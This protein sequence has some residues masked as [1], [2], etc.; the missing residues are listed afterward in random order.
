MSTDFDLDLLSEL[1]GEFDTDIAPSGIEARPPGTAAPL[2]L[3]QQRLWFLHELAEG[4]GAYTIGSSFRLQGDLDVDA[5]LASVADLIRR[6][7]SLRTAITS[8]DGVAE[9]YACPP[10]AA[11][12]IVYADWSASVPAHEPQRQAFLIDAARAMF[13]EPF[14]LQLGKPFRF[15][16]LRLDA[17]EHV[18]QVSLHHLFGD[19]TSITLL[20]RDLVALYRARR[21]GQPDGLPPL[22]VHYLDFAAWQRRRPTDWD[23]ALAFWRAQLADLATLD[24]P[25]DRSRP[26]TSRGKGALLEITIPARTTATLD[27]LARNEGTTLFPVVVAGFMSLLARY[28]RQTDIAVGTS[29]SGR[30]RIET[31]NMIGFFANMVVLRGNLDGAPSLRDLV[32]QQTRVIREA[33]NHAALPYERLVEALG[34]SREAG[35]NPL[36]QVA[37]SLLDQAPDARFD[38]GEGLKV[39]P[40]TTQEASR[41]DLEIFL[42]REGTQLSGAVSYDADLFERASV[43]RMMSQWVALLD[44]A[45]QQPD[46]PLAS[47]PL[48]AAASPP[49][50]LT[51][52]APPAAPFVSVDA[53]VRA[54]A[55][56][57]PDACALR[58]GARSLTYGELD[59]QAD[60]LA[61]RLLARDIGAGKHIGL[62]FEPGFAMIVSMLA[63]VRVGATYV[64]IDPDYPAERIQIIMEDAMLA[65]VLGDAASLARLPQGAAIPASTLE[66]L[67]TEALDTSVST[68]L[69]PGDPDSI[70][71]VIFTSG[72]TGRPKG[73][74]VSAANLARLF[75]TTDTLFDFTTADIWTLTH[76]YAF[77]FSVW[78]IWGAL[79]HGSTLLIVPVA[80]R[81]AADSLYALLCDERVTVLNQT[82]SSF[83]QLMAEEERTGREAELALRYVIFGGEA[84]ELSSLH[85]WIDRH[86]DAS[87]QLV[88]MYGITE[89]TV[90][91]TYRRIGIADVR[92]GSGSLIGEPLPDMSIRL[93]DDALRPVPAGMIGEIVVGGAGVSKG[94]LNRPELTSARFIDDGAGGML[95]RSGDL[96]RRDAHGRLEY[97][98]RADQQIKL[99][100]F[101]IELGEIEAVLRTHPSVADAT[102]MVIGNHES[103]R[104]AAYA[105]LNDSSQ[106]RTSWRDSFDMIYSG[107]AG[108][109]PND[110]L[111]DL[112]GWTDSYDG[113]PIPANEMRAW[114]DEILSRIGESQGQRVLEIGTGTGMLLLPL[115]AA[116]QRYDGLDFSAE[117]IERLSRVVER[118]G[119]TSVRL[120]A[121]GADDLA[122]LPHDYDTIIVNSVL[123]YFPDAAYALRVI[124]RALDHLAPGGRLILGDL[125]HL[126][127][128]RHFQASRLLY[129]IDRADRDRE[130]DSRREAL[131]EA[132][133]DLV[134]EEKELLVAPALFEAL[135]QARGDIASADI[136]LKTFAGDNELSRYRY[137]VIL[138]K[139]REDDG[140]PG[141]PQAT[142]PPRIAL[143]PDVTR[144]VTSLEAATQQRDAVYVLGELDNA[145]LAGTQAF[146]DW[147]DET[148]AHG[149]EPYCAAEETAANAHGGNPSELAD[150]ARGAGLAL[151][152]RWREG[153]GRGGFEVELGATGAL[154][155]DAASANVHAGNTIETGNLERFFNTPAR[156]HL[157][158]HALRQ[159]LSTRLPPY[160]VPAFVMVLD[161]LPLTPNGKLD[162]AA[163]PSLESAS[164]QSASTHADAAPTTATERAIAAVFAEVLGLAEV[165]RNDHFF[166]LGGHSLL[167]TQVMT[168]LRDEHGL[169][170]KLRVLFDHPVVADLASV[171][172]G[173]T[174]GAIAQPVSHAAPASI[175]SST[176]TTSTI[177]KLDERAQKHAAPAS[178]P[179]SF[180]QQRFWF[181]DRLAGDDSALYHMASVLRLQGAL[182]FTAV[183]R[184]I[185]ALGTRHESL[186]TAFTLVDDVP[187]QQVL[188]DLDV[189]LQTLAFAPGEHGEDGARAVARRFIWERFD[190]SIG[191]PIRV[192]L[193]QLAK[194]DALLI[195]CMHHIVSD[196]WSLGIFAREF[197]ALYADATP[198]APLPLRYFDHAIAQRA[199]YSDGAAEGALK[200]WLTRLEGAPETL[201]LAGERV[202]ER[203]GQHDGARLTFTLNPTET[204]RLQSLAHHSGVTLF[205]VLLTAY[206]AVL[207]RHAG[208]T[209]VV[210]GSPIAQRPNR[211]SEGIIGC[212]LNTLP[213][214]CTFD[215]QAT[216]QDALLRTRDVVLDA[217]EWQDV[218]FE[219]LVSALRQTRDL[220][221]T[222]VFQSFLSLQN[223]PAG[224]LTLPGLDVSSFDDG[225]ELSVQFKLT[226]LAQE[227]QENGT[228]HFDWLY[229]RQRFDK[230]VIEQLVV[231]FRALL[232]AMA[233]APDAL[234][235]DLAAHERAGTPTQ[236]A[237]HAVHALTS[238]VTAT[239]D[240]ALRYWRDTLADAPTTLRVPGLRPFV[241]A[242]GRLDIAIDAALQ[243]NLR[244]LGEQRGMP[245]PDLLFAAWSALLAR[246]SAQE[247]VVLLR[248]VTD[249]ADTHVE[250]RLV[251]ASAVRIDITEGL[252]ISALLE[253]VD[254]RLA[255]ARTHGPTPEIAFARD[256]TPVQAGFTLRTG[257]DASSLRRTRSSADLILELDVGDM[258]TETA[259]ASATGLTVA[260]R[261]AAERIDAA[262]LASYPTYLYRILS[263][264]AEDDSQP[265]DAISLLNEEEQR[266]QWERLRP[267]TYAD[268]PELCL[269]ESFAARASRTPDA[270]AV[271]DGEAS[272][273][274]AELDAR[275]NRLAHRLMRAGVQPDDRVVLFA[276]PGLDM[277]V[278]LLGILKA[279]A[280]YVPL[281]P[282]YPV[283]RVAYVLED[284]QPVAIVLDSALLPLLPP[285]S[286]PN[287]RRHLLDDPSLADESSLAPVVPALRTHHLAYVIY[288]SG[289]TGQPK[290]V[291]VEHRNVA[292]LFTTTETAYDFTERD[293]WALFHSFAF[294]FSVWEIWGAWLYGGRLVIVPQAVRRD[295]LA[296]YALL[297]DSGITVLN[298]TPSAFRQLVAVQGQSDARH[299][300]R[301]VIFG[302]E[303]LEPDFLA[304]WYANAM[305]VDTRLTNMYGITET[306]VHVTLHPLSNVDADPHAGDPNRPAGAIGMP[307]A[308]LQV[309]ILD[310]QRRPVPDGVV[311]EM[312][313]S[314]P[315][316]ARGYLNRPALTEARFISHP[317]GTHATD[318][319]YRSG[320]LARRLANGSLEYRGRNDQQVK[321]RGFRIELGEI[322]ARLRLF[323]G[324]G[325]ACVVV[326]DHGDGDKRLVAYVVPAT[327]VAAAPLP[328]HAPAAFARELQA[329]LNASLPEHMVPKV[330]VLVAALPLTA[331]GKL[332]RA[333]L[334]SP[335]T[336]PAAAHATPDDDA[337]VT[338][339]QQVMLSLWSAVLG[340]PVSER[341]RSFFDVGGD[342]LLAVKLVS[343]I[344][345]HFHQ[346]M[347]LATAFTHQTVEALSRYVDTCAANEVD[348][349]TAPVGSLGSEV[350][351]T[352]SPGPASK[353]ERTVPT[354]VLLHDISGLFVSQLPLARA[355]GSHYPV[356]G[357]Q[358]IGLDGVTAPLRSVEAMAEAYAD[359]IL[360]AGHGVAPLVLIGYSWG[361]PVSAYLARALA[362]RGHG[363]ALLVVLDAPPG[364]NQ[365]HF[366]DIPADDA[367]L[368]AYLSEALA[369]STGY[370]VTIPASGFAALE[371]A[372]RIEKF[373]ERCRQ[374]KLVPGD[375]PTSLVAGM[376]AVYRANLQVDA[377]IAAAPVPCPI[378]VWRSTAANRPQDVP[379]HL[380]WSVL[381]DGRIDVS[382]VDSDH[383]GMLRPPHVHEL[384]TAIQDR[385]A[386]LENRLELHRTV[387]V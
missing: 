280:A 314:G 197:A 119:L 173:S 224:R 6:H 344:E 348:T 283:D 303:A 100:G 2:S 323:D 109:G 273:S 281:D 56:Q 190:L 202:P 161:R 53:R 312:Y 304:A 93:V 133:R 289:S 43:E 367:G 178:A 52:T 218:P 381:S 61:Q 157:L 180:A 18:V 374:Q 292:R 174:N 287:L 149:T 302:G 183:R 11:A 209:E 284:S 186:R 78:E 329:W 213:L 230:T 55:A 67:N 57:R 130:S 324:A 162:R 1:S 227:L 177:E 382:I 124:Q 184:A 214:R 331:N 49:T 25:L 3:P 220:D 375:T 387:D 252:S 254:R 163:L 286:A 251:T 153:D 336:V 385:I 237:P 68:P 51:T 219:A 80:V 221:R 112:A 131:R 65:M 217:F 75:T 334:P 98:G 313:V 341:T 32:R 143:T 262:A 278:G 335:A 106:T 5:F 44:E 102:V 311:G 14:D 235:V 21:T 193:L 266:A 240:A 159:H 59:Q 191:P 199:R 222:P 28:A 146:L 30:D 24:L 212:F 160:M 298:Q 27:A 349:A 139:L 192:G 208:Q 176:S 300:L 148:D 234:L 282:T 310:A 48:G 261:Y 115:A 73:V 267:S 269:H 285:S 362:R 110:E 147:L 118:R 384:A 354:V 60:A 35:G 195:V 103:A 19:A 271:V 275:A 58:L 71:Y 87:P 371:P 40:V 108:E 126:G 104:L 272:F 114:R 122:D 99:R 167:A 360:D 158:S 359:S 337:P 45:A 125:R 378:A 270:I 293:V 89:T 113:A 358:A 255:A 132:L 229:D 111:L 228:L 185:S 204:A 233:N 355:L 339:T 356:L 82:P 253:Q 175:A 188:P 288:T 127:L 351:L 88:N 54:H 328:V 279:G 379:G 81:R 258:T 29:V 277:M 316:V 96:A 172:G 169:Q 246:L 376:V 357:L 201:M 70:A 317:L 263:A 10:D 16:L 256:A 297:C 170:L 123:Q 46:R 242:I 200:Q 257:G 239:Q 206:G 198:L 84:L 383:L 17:H 42:G 294:D 7:E 309:H 62:C 353:Q 72:S 194:D 350:L 164:R 121:R 231:E 138:T 364:N 76:S 295:P 241:P 338:P 63:T 386:S 380:G 91:V 105:V 182:D 41:F 223:T 211:D 347:S 322:E 50:A 250:D 94:Y 345:R 305:N 66:S 166:E 343:T 226:L 247:T 142:Q 326:E 38:I 274:Y 318:R 377:G 216:V 260:L 290:G 189:Q 22:R 150:I 83:R 31:Q 259:E 340:Q 152:A 4:G 215:P 128:L 308:D 373:A 95:Y 232:A 243:Q 265:V 120:M 129:R 361:A 236:P 137:D 39:E 101:R 330:C 107:D 268:A 346:K 301:H 244:T 368:L 307:I 85:G 372:A 370:D 79:V 47:L 181:L 12:D 365:K 171:I 168:R 64:P 155:R 225:D 249:P 291:M 37:I 203:P 144:D 366:A 86:G 141:S 306:T 9:Q 363:P 342:S 33:M 140:A 325:D 299:A 117:A 77:D 97:R 8:R 319:L 69:P 34:V 187:M 145:R 333:A 26:P 210:V 90:H 13:T 179:L 320:D 74:C 23:D 156:G 134:A 369:E 315:G 205:M 238:S 207:S 296:V 136:R 321:V 332:D 36:F 248:D 245:L 154:I 15:R 151:H 276:A 264:I 196:G 327:A 165:G 92:A 116:A 135:A 20:L 352:L